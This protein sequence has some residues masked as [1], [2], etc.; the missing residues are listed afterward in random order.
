MKLVRYAKTGSIISGISFVLCGLFISIF[1]TVSLFTICYA[2]GTI[3]IISGIIK[4]IGYFSNDL[5]SLA[6]QFDLALGIFSIVLGSVMII[7]PGLVVSF[8]PAVIGITLLINSLFTFQISMDSKKFG[9]D[10]W[11]ITLILSII[12]S[13]LGITIIINPFT[14]AKVIIAFVGVTIIIAGAEKI[15]TSIYTIVISKKKNDK[16][17]L[18]ECEKYEFIQGGDN[19]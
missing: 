6:F 8:F 10:Y 13:L 11:W 15:F 5:Y 17:N 4:I 19:N 18:I 9:L 12:T 16:S 3:I 2:I 7:R 1:P 14:S